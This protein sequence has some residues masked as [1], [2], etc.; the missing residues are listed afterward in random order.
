MFTADLVR[1][2]VAVRDKLEV[3][4]K[5]TQKVLDD[6]MTKFMT[7]VEE[8]ESDPE[9]ETDDNGHTDRHT[10]EQ[11]TPTVCS[12]SKGNKNQILSPYSIFSKNCS[13]SSTSSPINPNQIFKIKNPHNFTQWRN[14]ALEYENEFD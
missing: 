7:G 1:A 11:E 10:G 2:L 3:S 13:K 8:D 4:H 6:R 14:S 9:V 5:A 12:K